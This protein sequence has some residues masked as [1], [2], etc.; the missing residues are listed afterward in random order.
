M[1]LPGKIC[2]EFLSA[3]WNEVP[4]KLSP[5]LLTLYFP[6]TWRNSDD[7]LILT[8]LPCMPDCTAYHATGEGREGSRA[9]Q[10]SKS[11]LNYTER[12]AAASLKLFPETQTVTQT[13]KALDTIPHVL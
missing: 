12:E 3:L 10:L 11:Q 8:F 5:V 7:R 6:I 13:R 2:Q 4:S 1:V 9:L